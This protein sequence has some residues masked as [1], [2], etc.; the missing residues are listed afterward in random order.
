MQALLSVGFWSSVCR[1]PVS[2]IGLLNYGARSTGPVRLCRGR[3]PVFCLPGDR[4]RALRRPRVFGPS[5]ERMG[6]MMCREFP[7]SAWEVCF[8]ERQPP[9][10]WAPPLISISLCAKDR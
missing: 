2:P 7:I 8:F 4:L 6:E 3:G 10:P 9:S 5:G 1:Y